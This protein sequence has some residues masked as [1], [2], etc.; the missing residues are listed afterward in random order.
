MVFPLFF[1]HLAPSGPPL[2][3]T[4]VISSERP[5][6]H[7]SFKAAPQPFMITLAFSVI[8]HY[9]PTPRTKLFIIKQKPHLC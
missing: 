6:L 3:S 2:S 5:F 1:A 4:W 9:T 8:S 7:I